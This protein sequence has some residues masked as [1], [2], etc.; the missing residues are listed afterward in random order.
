M[1]KVDWKD[2]GPVQHGRR[3]SKLNPLDEALR[4]NPGKWALV[5]TGD[6]PCTVT[7]RFRSDLY[8]RAYRTVYEGGKKRHQVYVRF[9]GSTK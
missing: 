4:A 1:K 8:E 6:T 9:V 2:P 5:S 7:P 3:V